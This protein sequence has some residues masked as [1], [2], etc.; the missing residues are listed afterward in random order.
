MP[1]VHS[2]RSGQLSGA[3]GLG[4]DAG[5]LIMTSLSGAA[6]V[7]AI[8]RSSSLWWGR[9]IACRQL[10]GSRRAGG[11]SRLEISHPVQGLISPR[12]K[13]Q[14][15][16]SLKRIG[17][18]RIRRARLSTIRLFPIRSSLMCGLLTSKSMPEDPIRRLVRNVDV[19]KEDRAGT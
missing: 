7:T 3:A 5:R 18:K 6:A 10:S 17:C 8:G 12:R 14:A 9:V 4:T 1:A 15:H 16:P 13:K 2:S 19:P 11:R